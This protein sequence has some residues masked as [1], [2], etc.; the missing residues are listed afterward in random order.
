MATVGRRLRAV[1]ALAGAVRHRCS[2]VRTLDDE[3]HRTGFHHDGSRRQPDHRV[4]SGC[5]EPVAPQHVP[6]DAGIT[7]GVIAPDGRDGMLQHATQFTAAGI[8]IALRSGPGTADVRWRGTAGSSSSQATLGRGQRLR[9]PDA[10][11]NAPGLTAPGD[12]AHASRPDRDARREG[13]VI[14]ADG[15]EHRDPAAPGRRRSSTRPAAAMRT[16]PDFCSGS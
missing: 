10:A 11:A 16:A 4:S 5:D 9:R 7:L 2:R 3:L 12:R 15:R 8:P 1:R 14:Y 6:T 13:S